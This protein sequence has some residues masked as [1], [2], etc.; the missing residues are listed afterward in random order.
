MLIN[1]SPFRTRCD[2]GRDSVAEGEVRAPASGETA[3]CGV[4]T[5]GAAAGAAGAAGAG[6]RAR[7]GGVAR[8]ETGAGTDVEP[9]PAISTATEVAATIE[10]TTRIIIGRS[11]A[12]GRRRGRLAE[13]RRY[14]THGVVSRLDE[15]R[16]AALRHAQLLLPAGNPVRPHHPP[17][18]RELGEQFVGNVG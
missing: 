1:V 11:P 5:D 6:P 2:S 16:A 3:G 12:G 14:E 13:Q 9:Q 18:I 17:P 8:C 15:A 7:S 10:W 4:A